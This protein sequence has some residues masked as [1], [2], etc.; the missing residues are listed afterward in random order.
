LGRFTVG[1]FRRLGCFDRPSLNA[2]IG[3]A[4]PTQSTG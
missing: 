3:Y 2:R 1:S 4:K